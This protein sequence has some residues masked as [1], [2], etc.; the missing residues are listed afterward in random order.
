VILIYTD[1]DHLAVH[2]HAE[3]TRER[4]SLGLFMIWKL[5]NPIINWLQVQQRNHEIKE[6]WKLANE[7]IPYLKKAFGDDIAIDARIQEN[8]ESG[9]VMLLVIAE[10]PCTIPP[11]EHPEELLRQFHD[12]WWLDNCH[13][14]SGLVFDYRFVVDGDFMGD[15]E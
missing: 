3:N 5:L 11:L 12:D 4:R 9:D 1:I 13:R 2:V 14:G 6:M 7:S 10:L 8:P 15:L